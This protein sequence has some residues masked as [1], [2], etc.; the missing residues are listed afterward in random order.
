MF[1]SIGA[2]AEVLVDLIA[3][4][5]EFVEAVRP[6][7]DRQRQPDAR[8]DRIAAADP[9]PEAEHPGRLDAERGHLVELGRDGGEMV[10]DR[11]FAD[12]CAIQ[13]RAVAALVIVS[14]W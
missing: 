6:D 11:R 9:V 1:F 5:Q 12:P 7:R 8:P 4:A 14:W 3:A 10:A 13:A 2:V